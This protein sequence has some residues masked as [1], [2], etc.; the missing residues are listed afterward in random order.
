MARF[1]LLGSIFLPALVMEPLADALAERGHDV[2]VAGDAGDGT[3]AEVV[4]SYVAAVSD[5]PGAWLVAHSNAGNFVP[6]V[7]ERTD[8]VGA[9]FMDAVLP[10]LAG[11]CWPVVPVELAESL[12]GDAEND[13]LP[14]WTRWWAADEMRSLFPSAESFAQVDAVTPRVSSSYLDE[15]ADAVPG[16]SSR[17]RCAYL[18]FGDSY[19]QEAQRAE[20]A[21]WQVRRLELEHLGILTDPEL[22][23]AS[24]EELTL[25]IEGA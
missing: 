3:V 10:P 12:R 7:A 14:R 4:D 25:A 5:L 16:W 17:L 1:A 11:G 21:R 8:A 9:V 24:I 15:V 2:V 18:A 22:V 13:A 20:E 19:E 23:A 6:A